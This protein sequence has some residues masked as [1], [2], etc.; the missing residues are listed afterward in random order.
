V[1]TVKA[2]REID[3]YTTHDLKV[4]MIPDIETLEISQFINVEIADLESVDLSQ[5][6]NYGIQP[7]GFC[8]PLSCIFNDSP[9]KPYHA[10]SLLPNA[11]N[12]F[13]NLSQN[14]G[15]HLYADK[16]SGTM[17]SQYVNRDQQHRQSSLLEV[18]RQLYVEPTEVEYL[19]LSFTQNQQT[20]AGAESY[21]SLNDTLYYR[22]SQWGTST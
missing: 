19:S 9:I 7:T 18:P 4:A 11:A 22:T 16:D 5:I 21:A 8:Q 15:S 12:E 6:V 13:E 2:D 20:S 14:I 17:D 1:D 3:E 10:L